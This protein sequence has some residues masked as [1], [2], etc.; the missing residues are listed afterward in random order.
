MKKIG[1]TKHSKL[2]ILD[3]NN[4]I[5]GIVDAVDINDLISRLS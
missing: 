4:R 1:Q 2:P 5:M 3:K